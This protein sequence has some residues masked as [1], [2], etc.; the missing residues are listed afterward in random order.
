LFSAF[1]L[2]KHVKYPSP[3]LPVW[4]SSLLQ[5]QNRYLASPHPREPASL[6]PMPSAYFLELEAR[7]PL[8]L[9]VNSQDLIIV[10]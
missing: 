10:C 4:T 3:G 5:I 8:W 7:L 1:V 2:I 9:P 6:A